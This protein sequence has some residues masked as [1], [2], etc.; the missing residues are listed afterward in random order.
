MTINVSKLSKE[1]EQAGIPY[2]GVNADGV[3]WGVDENRTPIQNQPNVAAVILAHDPT[4]YDAI[5][6]AARLSAIQPFL[7]SSGLAGENLSAL[8]NNA[9]RDA[10]LKVICFLLGFA[11]SNGVIVSVTPDPNLE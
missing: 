1:L 11:D 7:I 8:N 5:D 10:L 6:K 4:D 3:V 9:D 2:S